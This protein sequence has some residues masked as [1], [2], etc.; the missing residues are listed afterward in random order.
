M[1]LFTSLFGKKG[2]SKLPPDVLEWLKQ[3]LDDDKFHT[4]TVLAQRHGL[5]NQLLFSNSEILDNRDEIPKM[6]FVTLLTSMGNWLSDHDE[7]EDA[8][9]AFHIAL[10]LLPEHD[11]AHSS[12]AILYHNAGRISEAKKHAALAIEGMKRHEDLFKDIPIEKR[13]LFKKHDSYLRDLLFR[14]LEDKT[15]C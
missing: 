10:S 7:N 1:S 2:G 5:F 9:A 13:L 8:E 11:P 14:I 15:N 4:L 3:E 12:L 6:Q